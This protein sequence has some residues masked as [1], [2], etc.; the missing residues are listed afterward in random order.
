MARDEVMM[1]VRRITCAAIAA[2][3]TAGAVL[4]R[5]QA[6]EVKLPPSPRGSAA[7][8]V[9]GSWTGTGNEKR[10]TGGQWITVDYG[11]PIMRGREAIFGAG[12]T[13][14]K[15]VNPDAPVWR[16][17]ANDTTRL[18]T[19]V[20]LTISGTT[21]QPGVYSVLVDLKE[22]AWTLVL[23]TQPV[24]PKYDPSDK[25]Q[26]YGAYNYD[27]KFDALRAPMKLSTSP[28]S[29][30]QFTIGFADVRSDRGSLYMAWDRTIAT[31]DFTVKK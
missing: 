3:V 2:A 17:G 9:A 20:P 24:M 19:Q 5:A 6:P 8:Q 23:S 22:N 15:T 12:A 13:Y 14:G 27:P 31:V 1:S 21:V 29:I 10:Y 7:V 11:R 28:M 30:E 26:L 25:V 4:V 16:A 18:T